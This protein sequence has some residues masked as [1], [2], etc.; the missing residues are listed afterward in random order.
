MGIPRWI[1]AGAKP[2]VTTHSYKGKIEANRLVI[3]DGEPFSI[4]TKRIFLRCN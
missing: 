1:Q 3:D 4:P 2:D